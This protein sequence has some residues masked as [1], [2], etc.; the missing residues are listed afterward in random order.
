VNSG[1]YRDYTLFRSA[2]FSAV[3]F[4]SKLILWPII[5]TGC[6][7]LPEVTRSVHFGSSGPEGR[8]ADFFATLDT[9]A[10]QSKTLD[11]GYARIK[12]YPYLRSDRFTAS[13]GTSLNNNDSFSA[14]VNR[15]QDLDQEARNFEIANLHDSDIA[16]RLTYRNRAEISRRIV[17]CGD[18]LKKIDFLNINNQQRLKQAVVVSDEYIDSRRILGIYPVTSLLVSHGVSRWHD[19]AR[20]HFSNRPPEND[21]TIRYASAAASDVL[22]ARKIIHQAERD[23]LGIPV[24]TSV[25]EKTLFQAFSPIWEIQMQ[26]VYDRI[27]SPFWTE[28][29]HIDVDTSSPRTY[30]SLSYTRYGKDV[31]TQLNYIIWF[32]SRPKT[33]ALDIYGGLLD[34][35]NYRV[36]LDTSGDP[37]LYETIHNCGCYYKAYPTSRL[38]IR[39]TMPYKEP[40]LILKAPKIDFQKELMVVSMD[41]RT[42][43]VRNLYSVPRGLD[44]DAEVYIHLPYNELKSLPFS[45]SKRKSMFNPY[46]IVTGSERLERYI[47]WPMGV[48]SPGAMRQWGKHAVAF[49]GK[50]HF[51]DPFYMHNMFVPANSSLKK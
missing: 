32:P 34:G 12:G 33:G 21:Q 39:K 51:D 5:L 17:S 38:Q 8:C 31:L 22:A 28:D 16:A 36:T 40:P 49:V 23:A 45:N 25:D 42:H 1:T 27:G 44:D 47:L 50:R 4:V 35:L 14:W 29:G 26:G 41:S 18:I 10:K 7:S 2:L 13:F 30:T 46:G 3:L 15:L 20:K 19:S 37:I 24:Y 43:Y 6:A 11:S 9:L 48:L